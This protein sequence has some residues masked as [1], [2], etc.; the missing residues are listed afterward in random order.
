[1]SSPLPWPLLYLE[2]EQGMVNVEKDNGVY[3]TPTLDLTSLDVNVTEADCVSSC[4]RVMLDILSLT[5]KKNLRSR[6]LLSR[7]VARGTYE[8]F[9]EVY[10]DFKLTVLDK[11]KRFGFSKIFA[12]FS[13][14][15]DMIFRVI[16]I[17]SSICFVL[18]LAMLISYLI[19][20][21]FPLFK[22]FGH[23]LKEIGTEHLNVR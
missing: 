1:M 12:F 2:F 16:L 7:K 14:H 13:E 11:K 4:V 10:H 8:H 17:V 18:A 5:N 21:D 3:L 6:K 23:S 19:F 15:K 20:G 9:P 22:L